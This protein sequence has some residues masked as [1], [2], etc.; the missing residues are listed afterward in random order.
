MKTSMVSTGDAMNVWEDVIIDNRA[1]RHLNCQAPYVHSML[2]LR[3]CL[4]SAV[5]L[6]MT[7]KSTYT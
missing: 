3:T 7:S 6:K 5:M 2:S 1:A 4:T